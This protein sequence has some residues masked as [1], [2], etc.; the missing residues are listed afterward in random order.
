[1]SENEGY[2]VENDR[3]A[4]REAMQEAIAQLSADYGN[5][6]D[7][8]QVGN[9]FVLEVER[10]NGLPP[11][12]YAYVVGIDNRPRK[13]EIHEPNSLWEALLA[14]MDHVTNGPNSQ[15]AQHAARLLW[16]DRSPDTCWHRAI[17]KH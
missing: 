12:F 13:V 7:V 2:F 16:G 6:V 17:R 4:K 9:V 11:I 1:M 3:P 14:A 15:R 8:H 10:Y 5:V